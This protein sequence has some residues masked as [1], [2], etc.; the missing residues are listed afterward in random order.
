MNNNSYGLIRK[1]DPKQVIVLIGWGPD[2]HLRWLISHSPVIQIWPKNLCTEGELTHELF[3]PPPPPPSTHSVHFGRRRQI[4]KKRF[5]Y[6]R[7]NNLTSNNFIKINPQE[8]CHPS[9]FLVKLTAISIVVF[10]TPY[11]SAVRIGCHF[12]HPQIPTFPAVAG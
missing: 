10:L 8:Y 7:I 11:R 12:L 6:R 1:N 4:D 3:L 2:G 5:H 9:T